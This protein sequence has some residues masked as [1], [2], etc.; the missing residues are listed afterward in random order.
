LRKIVRLK[1]CCFTQRIDAG[2]NEAVLHPVID[3]FRAGAQ[4]AWGQTLGRLGFTRSRWFRRTCKAVAI[5]LV[6]FSLVGFVGVPLLAQYVMAGRVAASLHRPVSMKKVRFNPYSLRLNIKKL[7]I[8]DRT[9]SER[10]LDFGYIRIKV[11]WKSLFRL[12]PVIG[13]V[14]IDRPAIHIVRTAEQ[15]FNFSDLLEIAG[16]TPAPSKPQW[17]AISNIQVHEGDVYFDDKVL[18]EQHALKHVELHVPFIA[19]LPSDVNVFVQPL[20]QM[21]V[22]GGL[23]RI[24][25]KARPFAVPPESVITKPASVGPSALRRVRA[26]EAAVQ[27]SA[28]TALLSI[29]SAFHQRRERSG[30][31]CE[32]RPDSRPA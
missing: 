17:F 16:P 28:R 5:V 7:R 8:G 13:E 23:V 6:I 30:D 9:S 24:A 1:I 12:A 3:K 2:A 21:V 18:N 25:G 27:I 19:N 32:R 11:S 4:R 15:R 29:A 26:K 10:F 31:P 14:A 22:D 20:L